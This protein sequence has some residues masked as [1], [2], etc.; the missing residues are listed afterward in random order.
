VANAVN[1]PLAARP[2]SSAGELHPPRPRDGPSLQVHDS[3]LE[4]R[5]NHS[6]VRHAARA[7]DPIG[8][9]VEVRDCASPLAQSKIA[10]EVTLAD[11]D[12]QPMAVA[13]L[14]RLLNAQRLLL[15]RQSPHEPVETV[16]L[17]LAPLGLLYRGVV[18]TL[19]CIGDLLVNVGR[20][21]PRVVRTRFAPGRWRL[22]CRLRPIVATATYQQRYAEKGITN[23]DPTTRK[24]RASTGAR[25]QPWSK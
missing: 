15:D 14:N 19:G 16:K 5:E 24:H 18:S 23:I 2:L 1:A 8:F 12:E 25:S 13:I 7:K 20:S 4:P 11:R 17:A 10:K 6:E 22:A 21:L 9:G 3:G